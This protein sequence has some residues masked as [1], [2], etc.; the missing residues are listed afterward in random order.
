MDYQVGK[1]IGALA[2]KTEQQ[3]RQVWAWAKEEIA[4]QQQAIAKL[5]ARIDELEKRDAVA[6]PGPLPPAAGL[7]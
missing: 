3:Y 5:T 4:T 6:N 2:E 1:D 7:G